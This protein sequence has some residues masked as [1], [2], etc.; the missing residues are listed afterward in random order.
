MLQSEDYGQ[1]PSVHLGWGRGTKLALDIRRL[2]CCHQLIF[3]G[4]SSKPQNQ[5]LCDF[6]LPNTSFQMGE[7]RFGD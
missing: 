6:S 1:S 3:Q 5:K 2:D 7:M 4:A